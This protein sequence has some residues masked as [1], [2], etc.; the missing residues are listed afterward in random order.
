MSLIRKDFTREVKKMKRTL[1]QGMT[2]G[3][4]LNKHMK[5]KFP[6][7]YFGIF[8]QDTIPRR[9]P[10]KCYL[11]VNVDKRS[12][13]GSHW[14]GLYKN[15][16]NVWVFDT[17]AR[18]SSKL[19]PFL[20]KQFNK[21]QIRVIDTHRGKDQTDAQEDCGHRVISFFMMVKKYGIRKTVKIL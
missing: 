2:F 19:V 8:S 16:K 9:I 3:D 4:E 21:Q 12:Q 20:V 15:G 13:S 18:K 14:L 1:G 5:K 7:L 17:F 10:R 11:I 6:K